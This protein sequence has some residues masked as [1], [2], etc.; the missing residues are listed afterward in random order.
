MLMVA[1]ASQ[2]LPPVL[3]MVQ[4]VYRGSAVQLPAVSQERLAQRAG[5]LAAGVRLGLD[6][7]RAMLRLRSATKD[8]HDV[9]RLDSLLSRVL[10]GALSI[11]RADFGNI[12]LFDPV[13][14]SLWIVTQS[15]FGPEFVDYFGVVDDEHSACGRAAK[16]G[17][18]TVIADVLTDPGF[19]PHRDIAAISGFRAVQSTPLAD[20]GGRLIGMLSTHFRRPH[21]PPGPDLVIM[22]LYGYFAGEAV[23]RHLGVPTGDGLDDPVGR[24]VFSALLDPGGDQEP[25]TVPSGPS[26]RPVQP[27][28]SLEEAMAGLA[29]EIV[30]RLFSVG[31]SLESARSIVGDGPAADRVAS[32]TGDVDRLIRDVRAIVFDLIADHG[33]R[34]QGSG[35]DR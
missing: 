25:A 16:E 21:R 20:Y 19:A 34:P 4:A 24:A 9:P 33:K 15:G 10:D 27:S 29:E 6:E 17:T 12:Q 8:L 2:N 14:K 3:E 28:A 5:R 13:T 22:E 18:Q 31:L 23:A 32:A 7:P 35:P 26:G 30:T 11:T 1:S